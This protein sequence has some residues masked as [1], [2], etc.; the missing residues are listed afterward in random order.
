[1]R[2]SVRILFAALLAL[3]VAGTGFAQPRDVA[4]A[5]LFPEQRH[6]KMML[7]MNNVFERYHYRKLVLDEQFAAHIL[8]NYLA[9]LDPN[10]SF[11]LAH[12]VERFER[13]LGRLADDL[14]HGYVAAAFDVFRLY[15]M[16]VE[17]QVDYAL[18]LL[19]QPF[20]FSTE[21]YYAFDRSEAPWATSDEELDQIWRQ[22][23][24]N[25]ALSL[26]LAG[27]DDEAIR[28]Q[29]RKRYE[30]LARRVRQFTNDD[31]FET[32]ANAYGQALEPHT[33]F[34][35]AS[36]SENFDISMR[37]SLEGIG[38]VLRADNDMTVVQRTIPGGPA[39]ESGKLHSGDRIVG[40]GEGDDG[41]IED[42]VGWRLQDV[43]D[44]IRGPK[45]TVVRLQ[46]LPRAVGAEG[47][48]R[49]VKLVRNEIKLEDQ[50]AQARV[51]DDLD[52]APGVR[53]GVIEIS[54]FYRDFQAEANGVKD[55]RSTTRDVRHLIADLD[56]QGID[57]LV[58]DLRGNGGGSLTEA[59]ALT[60]LFIDKG[61]V[62]QVRDS[63]GRLEV[64]KDP[65]AG[66]VYSGPLAILVDRDSASASE[67]FAGAIQ[68]YGRGL[69]IGEPTFG[70]GTV[71]TLIELNRF[72][73]GGDVDLGRLRLTMAQFYRVDGGSTQL[74]G[75][76][77][78]ILLPSADDVTEHGERS[79]ENPLPWTKIAALDHPHLTAFGI[80]EL[81]RLSAQRVAKDPGF[82][83]LVARDNILNEIN[84]ET[85]VSLKESDRRAETKRRERVLED[86]KNAFLGTRG[87][88]P[89]PLDED[90][91]DEEALEKERDAIDAIQLEEAARILADAVTADNQVQRPR[92]A[93]SN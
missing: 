25:D 19:A 17:H 47:P 14:R 66:V 89:V 85:R 13:N 50:A 73:P 54:A 70:K 6:A 79:L 4:L 86:Q 77:P 93:M 36:T 2:L 81:R 16:R 83:M 31:V 5:D 75:V 87:I 53:I 90:N 27:K 10:R 28:E 35:S 39:G 78:D 57:G 41:P 91:P 11:F 37:L 18:K 26:R 82:Q 22:R 60:G 72:V 46:V 42:V 1:M 55:F 3:L 23:V 69:V 44:K 15:R 84:D 29:L 8:D 88:T 59:T 74:R 38:A 45:G 67:I 68:D 92:A 49:N 43:V 64:E 61:P 24:K 32:F 33:S 52:N 20:D 56:E 76:E 51:L 21:E 34:M 40:V 71:Q 65:E 80:E 12:D 9:A 30:G 7:V 58:I 63:S 62:V 48:T